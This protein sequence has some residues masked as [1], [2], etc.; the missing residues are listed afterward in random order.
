MN[1]AAV[2]YFAI[3]LGIVGVIA[4]SFSREPKTEEEAQAAKRARKT[5]DAA[6]ILERGGMLTYEEVNIV[7]KDREKKL[8]EGEDAATLPDVL[9]RD[10]G[11]EATVTEVAQGVVKF[12]LDDREGKQDGPEIIVKVNPAIAVADLPPPGGE[13]MFN[14]TIAEYRTEEDRLVVELNPGL[15]YF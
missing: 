14:G 4:W 12:D 5:L 2:T 13:L 3:F 1:K 10:F 8:A 15:V 6:T 11:G 7:V 9:G